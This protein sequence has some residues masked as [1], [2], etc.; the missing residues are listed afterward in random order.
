[1]EALVQ[2]QVHGLH[3]DIWESVSIPIC[4]YVNIIGQVENSKFASYYSI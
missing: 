3:K 4:F 2:L 1:M